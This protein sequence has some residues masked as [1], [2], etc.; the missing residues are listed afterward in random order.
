MAF[1]AC[2]RDTGPREAGY[3]EHRMMIDAWW[4]K[5]GTRLW[6]RQNVLSNTLTKL[7]LTS[8]ATTHTDFGHAATS[9]SVP[10]DI[11][12]SVG[13]RQP[14]VRGVGWYADAYTLSL[15][16]IPTPSQHW[17]DH[18]L[19]CQRVRH[20]LQAVSPPWLLHNK[21]QLPRPPPSSPATPPCPPTLT[22]GCRRL[23]LWT[24]HKAGHPLTCAQKSAAWS[25]SKRH[26]YCVGT[27][28]VILRCS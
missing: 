17:D 4:Y 22:H 8:A 13:V 1:T 23:F 11:A 18:L 2:S 21:M 14:R 19:R 25:K 3:C 5:R 27:L 26:A 6:C 20:S 9:T 12:L 7:T 28:L 10:Q 15:Y 16:H 24:S